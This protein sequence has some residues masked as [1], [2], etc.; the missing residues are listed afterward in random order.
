[1]YGARVALLLHVERL[2]SESCQLPV[3]R[4]IRDVG[5][6]TPAGKDDARGCEMLR[7]VGER[8]CRWIERMPQQE[9]LFTSSAKHDQRRPQSWARE[10]SNMGS[11][12]PDARIF[13]NSTS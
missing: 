12:I 10:K 4:M 11:V 9:A 7:A 8:S 2:P 6:T 13:L 3:T 1:M 5:S